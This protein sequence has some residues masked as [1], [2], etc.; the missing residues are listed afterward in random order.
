M[1]QQNHIHY[2]NV[3]RADTLACPRCE[4]FG[5]TCPVQG[6]TLTCQRCFGTGEDTLGRLATWEA[7]LHDLRIEWK[8]YNGLVA[9]ARGGKKLGMSK[10]L[11]ALA[12]R[13]V[14]LKAH[15]D[16]LKN[17]ILTHQAPA[18]F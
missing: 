3:T 4:G 2:E 8:R 15:I 16:A 6:Q 18:P 9:Q 12:Q 5:K 11:D 10:K 14:N 13:G 1:E 17:E 7:D